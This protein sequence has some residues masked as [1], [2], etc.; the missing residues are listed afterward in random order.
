MVCGQQ[1]NGYNTLNNFTD[2]TEKNIY[3]S[4]A[5]ITLIFSIFVFSTSKELHRCSQIQPIDDGLF[6]RRNAQVED[7]QS[8]P[9]PF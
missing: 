3:T 7:R 4:T 9:C 1:R 5:E 2:S 6:T 8:N